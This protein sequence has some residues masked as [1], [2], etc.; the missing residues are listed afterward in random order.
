M[1]VQHRWEG[2][3]FGAEARLEKLHNYRNRNSLPKA[4]VSRRSVEE[5]CRM[6][7]IPDYRAR[8]ADLPPERGL[9]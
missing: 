5:A 8:L 2:D 6:A 9:I 1:P 3:L 4:S 7:N